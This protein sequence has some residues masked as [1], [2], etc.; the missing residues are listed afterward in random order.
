[1]SNIE[2]E[3]DDEDASNEAIDTVLKEIASDLAGGWK[4]NDWV[5]VI[6]VDTWYPGVIND[7]CILLSNVF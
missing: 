4:K 3:E 2:D 1:M 5:A 7:V 6:Y